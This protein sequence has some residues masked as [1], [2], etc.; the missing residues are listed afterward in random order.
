LG[1]FGFVLEIHF[2]GFKEG[3]AYLREEVLGPAV[4]KKASFPG[5]DFGSVGEQN[6]FVCEGWDERRI[7]QRRGVS[8][9]GESRVGAGRNASGVRKCVVR[10]VT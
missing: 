2:M 5:E 8:L 10:L 4:L 9:A 3:L 6:I 7:H 1:E